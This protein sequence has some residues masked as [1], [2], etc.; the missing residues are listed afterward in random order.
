MMP[1]AKT[2][3]RWHWLI[4]KHATSRMEVLTICLGNGGEALAVFNFEEEAKM[5]LDLRPAASGEEW[6]VR[7]TSVGEL[8]SI[9][10]GPCSNARKVALDPVPEIGKKEL[11]GPSIVHR[12]DFLRLLLGEEEPSKLH[13]VAS[14]AHGSQK[15]LEHGYVA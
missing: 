4:T 7:Q 9:L 8:V 10:H 6:R 5:F 2:A 12:H 3:G 1:K 15:T 14:L 11:A 13:L